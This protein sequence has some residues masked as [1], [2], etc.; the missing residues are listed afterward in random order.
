MMKDGHEVK[1]CFIPKALYISGS[2]RRG[3]NTDALLE[4]VQA[5]VPGEFIKLPDL[6]IEPCRACWTCQTREQ[7]VIEDELTP[8][9]ARLVEVDA[10][11]LGSP[12]YF[13]NVSSA[14]K[15]FIDRTWSL[16]GRLRNKIGG[17][18]VVGRRD[19]AESALTALQAFFLK[20][21]MI[22]ANRGVSGVAFEVGDMV[23]DRPALDAAEA[24]GERLIELGALL[25]HR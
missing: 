13:N 1:G 14:M 12:V 17:A 21:E 6:A 19:G 2:P 18:V 20:H 22:P 24:L 5:V 25:Q 9:L 8:I 10:L 7:C 11:V 15:A 23:K 16:R 3:S 4:R